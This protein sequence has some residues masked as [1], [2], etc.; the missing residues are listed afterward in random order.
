MR[1]ASEPGSV[2]RLP[3]AVGIGLIRL[4]RLTLSP[5]LGQSC[6]YLP[7]CSSYGEEAISRHG[8]W[9][10]GWMT[11]ARLQR[12]GPFGASGYDPVPEAIPES[13]HWYVPW[14]YGYWTGRHIDPATR[15]D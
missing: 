11:L 12:C 10:G 5:F 9:A 3:R 2:S 1:P 15:L 6:R 13:A 7:T 8:L 14:R 4:Y